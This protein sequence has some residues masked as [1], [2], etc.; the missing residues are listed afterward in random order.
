MCVCTSAVHVRARVCVCARGGYEGGG[1]L[2]KDLF[3]KW[4]PTLYTRAKTLLLLF[5]ITQKVSSILFFFFFS[6][7]FL[8][9]VV[10][11]R[12]IHARTQHTVPSRAPR[13]TPSPA[14]PADQKGLKSSPARQTR[15][16]RRRIVAVTPLIS[17]FP[18][19]PPPRPTLCH[20]HTLSRARRKALR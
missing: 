15:P 9:P 18:D 11:S 4:P 3:T 2:K 6:L 8:L 12:R 1:T 16:C 13:H 19:S 20:T 10:L 17:S 5:P 14:R 7:L